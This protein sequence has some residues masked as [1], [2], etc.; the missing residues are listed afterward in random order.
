MDSKVKGS[1]EKQK[2]INK[3]CPRTPTNQ[4]NYSEWPITWLPN[5]QTNHKI[6]TAAA[7]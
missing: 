6:Q 1:A 3:K 7:L 4:Q 2:K 5:K